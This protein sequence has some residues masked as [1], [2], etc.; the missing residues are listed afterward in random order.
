MNRLHLC[1]LDAMRQAAL[2]ALLHVDAA[3]DPDPATRRL[4]L[5]LAAEAPPLRTAIG[6]L[7]VMRTLAQMRAASV[8][9]LL[10][11]AALDPDTPQDAADGY[12]LL[13]QLL[14]DDPSAD[15]LLQDHLRADHLRIRAG[16][17]L[18]H[19]I[20]ATAELRG[21]PHRSVLAT[22]R[23]AILSARLYGEPHRP[24]ITFPAIRDQA[25]H[26]GAEPRDSTERP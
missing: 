3:T 1:L 16:H 22:A 17:A 6:V 2:E 20:D 15:D 19:Q 12:A 23:A 14:V 13:Q 18:H 4:K 8:G 21:I 9:D 25:L 26:H 24:T 10:T 11:I 5:L 7:T